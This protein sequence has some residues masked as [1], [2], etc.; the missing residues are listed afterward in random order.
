MGRTTGTSVA[1]GLPAEPVRACHGD[2][3]QDQIRAGLDAYLRAMLAHAPGTRLGDDP[4]ELH[5]MR[6]AVR[7]MRAL[8]KTGQSFLDQRWSRPLRAELGWLADA[9]GAVRDLD[10]LLERLRR[11][12]DSLDG[13]ERAAFE[14]LTSGLADEH[15]RDRQKLVV[16]LDSDRYA[17]LVDRLVAAVQA[18]PWSSSTDSKVE[19]R[20]IVTAQFH[21]LHKQVQR[22]GM[23]ATDT[24][25]HAL[26]IQGKRLRYAS[27]LANSSNRR[28]KRLVAAC[29]RFQD[30]LGEHQDACVATSRITQLL[31][32]MGDRAD[33]TVAF[34]A[35]RLVEREA[36][37]R[38]TCR[39]QWWKCWLELQEC[40]AKYTE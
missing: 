24:Q 9:L 4:E 6:V 26:R 25:L 19:L 31:N 35:G 32:E 27:E 29:K 16:V 37:R 7:K 8:L 23:D 33:T 13:A 38:A 34:V 20:E 5:Q 14:R 15:A 21:K 18:P 39:A 30:M 22:A 10:V 3:V 2:P 17:Y 1:A 11:R 36:V 40:A 28:T 12:A